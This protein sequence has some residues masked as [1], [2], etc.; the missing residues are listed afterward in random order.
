MLQSGAENLGQY[1]EIGVLV[2]QLYKHVVN[3]FSV[4]LQNME[5]FNDLLINSAEK[6]DVIPLNFVSSSA[7]SQL[8]KCGRLAKGILRE[9]ARLF[10]EKSEYGFKYLQ[11]TGAFSVP[12]SPMAVANFLRLTPDIPKEA[13][14]AYLGELGKENAKYEGNDKLFHAQVLSKYVC[15]FEFEGQGILDCMRI[16]LSAFRLPG[17]AQQIDRILVL[18]SEFCHSNSS[19]GRSGLLENPE[20]TYLLSFSIIMLNTDRHNP[21]IRADRRMTLDQFVR[22]NTNYGKDVNQT[23]PLPRSFLESIF[24]SISDLPI[25][26]QNHDLVSSVTVEVWKDM[27]LQAV[28]DPRKSVFISSNYSSNF[29]DCLINGSNQSDEPN[30]VRWSDVVK[31]GSDGTNLLLETTTTKII[32]HLMTED[33]LVFG[34]PFQ[35]IKCM[36]GRDWL[37]DADLVE[38]MGKM[39]LL[40]GVSVHNSNFQ[41]NG[42]LFPSQFSGKNGS[43]SADF[44]NKKIKTERLGKF[45]L[46]SNEFLLDSLRIFKGYNLDYFLDVTILLFGGF[47]GLINVRKFIHVV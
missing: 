23:V 5:V 41:T 39:M 30:I 38:S 34:D 29:I 31:R 44:S 12:M 28:V 33:A 9:A 18:F 19:E 10:T 40:V 7:L 37:V 27:Q 4:R 3:T 17:E 6:S 35:L 25:R 15:S 16:F 13:V 22:N 43:N 47:S 11:S 45:L 20:V 32:D 24:H 21:N 8:F 26:T 14:G 2:V 42:I 36:E 1:K 46:L